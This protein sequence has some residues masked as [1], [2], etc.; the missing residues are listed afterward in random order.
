MQ[1]NVYSTKGFYNN[2]IYDAFFLKSIHFLSKGVYF[3]NCFGTTYRYI[4]TNLDGSRRMDTSVQMPQTT[5]LQLNLPYS[6]VGI[7]RSN[8]YV[9][10]F[11]II[12]STRHKNNDNY[13]IYTPIIPNSQLI[14]S[15]TPSSDSL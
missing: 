5:N 12:T 4:N 6:F 10:N 14:I 15:S 13:K 1:N 7:G 2:Y 9:E 3:T 8:N 11:A